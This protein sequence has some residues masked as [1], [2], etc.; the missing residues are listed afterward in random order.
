MS[1]QIEVVQST[2]EIVATKIYKSPEVE[3]NEARHM[4]GLLSDLLNSN[5]NPVMIKG[6]RYLEFE[7]WST[8]GK[9]QGLSVGTRAEPVEVFGAKGAKGIAILRDRNGTIISEAEAFCLAS[10]DNSS[11]L[12]WFQIASKA[13]TRAGSKAFRNVLSWIVVLAGYKPTPAEEIAGTKVQK[14]LQDGNK[15][16]NKP[17]TEHEKLTRV[18]YT[19]GKQAGFITP[20]K[21]AQ[22]RTQLD[23][24]VFG[25]F[26]KEAGL[27]GTVQSLSDADLTKAVNALKAKIDA[28][29][30]AKGKQLSD[31]PDER[32]T[33]GEQDERAEEPSD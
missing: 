25:H 16:G 32:E 26:L 8:L 27:V 29:N 21:D 23:F 5:P 7:D 4:A 30:E 24:K 11:S 33:T 15:S 2:G 31:K 3:M 17:L 12:D 13:Q 19:L 14:Q 10:E 6:E 28:E 18:V 1:K 9:W 22:G 20:E